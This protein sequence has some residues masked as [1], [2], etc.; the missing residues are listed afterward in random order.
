MEE[1]GFWNDSNDAQEKMKELKSL[2]SVVEGFKKLE[3][4]FEDIE[5][6]IEMGYEE[7]D[8]SLI[9]EIN[10][11]MNTFVSDFVS[12]RLS[13]LLSGEYDSDNAILTLHAEPAVQKAVIG[14]VCFAVC[15][16]D[17]R[18]KKVLKLKCLILLTGMKPE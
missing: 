9:E 7:E 8:E 16:R 14:Q 12:L 10:E 17:G 15:I 11:E 2:E 6:L 4:R 1:P 18:I 3:T 5:T 13:T